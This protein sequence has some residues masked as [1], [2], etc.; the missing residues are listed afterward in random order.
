[1]IFLIRECKILYS[2]Y[3]E[4]KEYLFHTAIEEGVISFYFNLISFFSL[5]TIFNSHFPRVLKQLPLLVARYRYE[6]ITII[7]GNY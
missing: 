5:P 2:F 7:V 3:S 4:K 1:M 6:P